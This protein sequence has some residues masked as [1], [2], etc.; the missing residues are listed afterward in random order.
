MKVKVVLFEHP[1]GAGQSHFGPS[2]TKTIVL[3]NAS[4][5]SLIGESILQVKTRTIVYNIPLASLQ[6]W[7]QESPR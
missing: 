2:A 7:E 3:E 5:P 6:Y 4:M 1:G